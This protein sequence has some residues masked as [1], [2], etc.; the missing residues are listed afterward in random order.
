MERAFDVRLIE[1]ELIYVIKKCI[2][3][4]RV[5]IG[6]VPDH[7]KYNIYLTLETLNIPSNPEETFCLPKEVYEVM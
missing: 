6:L 4:I 2:A 5:T 7:Y 1:K 3:F